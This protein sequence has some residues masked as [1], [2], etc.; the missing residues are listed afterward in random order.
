MTITKEFFDVYLENVRKHLEINTVENYVYIHLSATSE[1]VNAEHI[2]GPGKKLLFKAQA[3]AKV[4]DVSASYRE[5]NSGPNI[6]IDNI[7]TFKHIR[8]VSPFTNKEYEVKSTD[9]G[10]HRVVFLHNYSEDIHI[11][12]TDLYSLYIEPEEISKNVQILAN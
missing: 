12:G 1:E 8:F 11:S 7:R 3:I 6:M 10:A 9:N 5:I 4:F 2:Y